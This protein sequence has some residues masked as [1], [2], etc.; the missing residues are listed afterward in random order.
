MRLI[1]IIQDNL[2]FPNVLTCSV[3]SFGFPT[4]SPVVVVNFIGTM[5][6]KLFISSVTFFYCCYKPLPLSWA[7]VVLWSFP[8]FFFFLISSSSPL[9]FFIILIFKT[10]YIFS[11]FIPLCAFPNVL[12]PLQL[13][14][15]VYKSSPSISI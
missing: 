5:K 4:P 6:S 12:L 7:F 1:K 2:S 3:D 11:T 8:I 13:I 15:N 10:Y 14:F 9:P